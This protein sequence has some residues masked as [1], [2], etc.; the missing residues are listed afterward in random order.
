L[1]RRGDDHTRDRRI[2]RPFVELRRQQTHHVGSDRI[3]RLWPVERDNAG[4]TAARKHDLGLKCIHG[5]RRAIGDGDA[6]QWH[7]AKP[8]HR[9]ANRGSVNEFLSAALSYRQ[10]RNTMAEIKPDRAV[11]KA[12]MRRFWQSALGFWTGDQRRIAWL[13]TASLIVLVLAQL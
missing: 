2:A 12:L 10:K 5:R 11:Q 3:E 7:P 1:A 13:M 4:R 9:L 6:L 8:A